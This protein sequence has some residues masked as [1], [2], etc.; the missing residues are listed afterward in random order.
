M[1]EAREFLTQKLDHARSAMKRYADKHR[2]DM[3]FNVEDWVYLRTKNLNSGRPSKKLDHK[4]VG[5][6]QIIDK[7][8]RLAYKLR[9]TPQYRGIHATHHVSMLEPHHG[10]PPN[11]SQA[12]AAI[13]L[14]GEPE[15]F[16]ER[17]IDHKKRARSTIYRVK[18]LGYNDSESTWEP[19]E[20]VKDT[21]ALANYEQALQER[22]KRPK[23]KRRRR[24]K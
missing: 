21:E 4:T 17:V 22:T 11:T 2:K 23:Q 8:G 3:S 9:L 18:W 13:E 15:Y 12:P 16:I 20:H 10:P 6:F 7:V 19:L 1:Q 5:P 14:D 24:T